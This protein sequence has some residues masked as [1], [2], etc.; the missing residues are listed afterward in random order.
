M[1]SAPSTADPSGLLGRTL[2]GRYQ[3]TEH[4]GSGDLGH[5]YRAEQV[6]L[7]KVCVIKVL[8]DEVLRDPAHRQRVLRGTQ[9][10]AQLPFDWLVRPDDVLVHD[11]HMAIVTPILGGED[12]ESLL[13]RMHGRLPWD[14][15]REILLQ[16]CAAL[17][18]LHAAGV[19][20]GGLKP[21]NVFLARSSDGITR[22]RILDV[23]TSRHDLTTASVAYMAPEWAAGGLPDTSADIYSLG[24]LAY[25][26]LTGQPVFSGAPAQVALMHR[27][28]PPR[29]LHSV[30]PDADVPPHAEAMLL[31]ALAKH[32]HERP[33]IQ[34]FS[35]AVQGT[36]GPVA[37]VQRGGDTLAG[38][39]L[40]A[41]MHTLAGD[42]V[43]QPGQVSV[44]FRSAHAPDSAARSGEL[45]DDDGF[46]RAARGPRVGHHDPLP[47]RYP[48]PSEYPLPPEDVTRIARA[49]L[50][51]GLRPETDDIPK[52][53]VTSLAA[54]GGASSLASATAV[55]DGPTHTVALGPQHAGHSGYPDDG[56]STMMVAG[57]GGSLLLEGDHAPVLPVPVATGL[58]VAAPVHP[59]KHTRW[60]QLRQRLGLA[61]RPPAPGTPAAPVRPGL[62]ARFRRKPAAGNLPARRRGPNW[63]ERGLRALARI[64]T[65]I[66]RA[67]RFAIRPFSRAGSLRS[68][69]AAPFMS[70]RMVFSRFT[71]FVSRW[72]GGAGH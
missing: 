38:D 58:A 26:M 62:L 1:S 15:A 7:R 49:P 11:D 16:I 56:P 5:V 36:G 14:H 25:E 71:R 6:A 30:A 4:I 68:R 52:T 3:L 41:D 40:P 60:S 67:W 34:A 32:P 19:L 13:R 23:G 2:G 10:V 59:R 69:F 9:Q 17:T 70:L 33:N 50:A 55:L 20:F 45:P 48:P 65:Y 22:V 8:R 28:K 29:P 63:F 37:V 27:F 53:V 12:L 42:M 24:S 72:T 47:L 64:P 43:F 57:F 35:A 51:P 61:R 31:R 66:S 18:E 21:R 54:V 39:P 46:A 44:S